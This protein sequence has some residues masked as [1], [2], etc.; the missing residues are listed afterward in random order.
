MLRPV[1]QAVSVSSTSG[2]REAVVVGL[3]A[4]PKRYHLRFRNGAIAYNVAGPEGLSE[5]DTVAV[6]TYSGTNRYLIV[7]RGY[8]TADNVTEIE[9]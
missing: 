3:T 1:L 4:H 5:S 9:V 6:T 8:N 7:E 2:V